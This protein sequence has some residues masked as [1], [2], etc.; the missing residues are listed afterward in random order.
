[1]VYQKSYSKIQ[2]RNQSKGKIPLLFVKKK[3]VSKEEQVKVFLSLKIGERL[4]EIAS[5]DS[6]DKAN[7]SKNQA[8]DTSFIDDL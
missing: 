3:K 5:G 7:N 1:M 4:K 2:E 8:I 6:L